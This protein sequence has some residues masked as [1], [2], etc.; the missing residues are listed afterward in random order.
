[1]YESFLELEMKYNNLYIACNGIKILYT[2]NLNPSVW[3]QLQ[4][5][6][7]QLFIFVIF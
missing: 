6:A 5:I 2:Q 4:R 7:L 3:L 1:M